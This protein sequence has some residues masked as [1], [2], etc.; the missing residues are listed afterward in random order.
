MINTE[1][2]AEVMTDEGIDLDQG[3]G[4]VLV[5]AQKGQ[6]T[7]ASPAIHGVFTNMFPTATSHLQQFTTLSV[8]PVQAMTQQVTRHASRCMLG[9]SLL[10]LMSSQFQLSS[11]RLWLQS[12][13]TLL[14]QVMPL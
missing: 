5:H 14:V 8:L 7:G 9:A 13:E 11:V 2:E 6:I 3:Q 1:A 4:H 12:E 10:Q